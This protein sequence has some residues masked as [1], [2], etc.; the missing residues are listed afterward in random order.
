[1]YETT[2]E[3]VVDNELYIENFLN[4]NVVTVEPGAL[5][6]ASITLSDPDARVTVYTDNTYSNIKDASKPL[7]SGN[8]IAMKNDCR[9][10]RRYSKR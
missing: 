1:M 10:R 9:I 4:S 5:F 3:P 2:F 8:I 6:S 7:E